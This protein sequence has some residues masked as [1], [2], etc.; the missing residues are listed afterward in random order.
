MYPWTGVMTLLPFSLLQVCVIYTLFMQF[1]LIKTFAIILTVSDKFEA[2][3]SHKSNKQSSVSTP[4]TTSAPTTTG[5]ASSTTSSTTTVSQDEKS[6]STTTATT[7][8][9]DAPTVATKTSV[10]SIVLEFWAPFT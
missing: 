4:T 10:V 1:R 6:E 3:S 2:N 8:S 9:T 5:T 7:T